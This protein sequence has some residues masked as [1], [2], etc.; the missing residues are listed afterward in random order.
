M[1]DLESDR[2]SMYQIQMEQVGVDIYHGEFAHM[3][4]RCVQCAR[5]AEFEVEI[6]QDTADYWQGQQIA[7]QEMCDM[8]MSGFDEAVAEHFPE[9][10][11]LNLKTGEP[12]CTTCPVKP[13]LPIKPNPP[14]ERSRQHE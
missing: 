5:D 1:S 13:I 8:V 3:G 9:H 6:T 14:I 2:K 7:W 4:Y 10:I 12:R 11:P